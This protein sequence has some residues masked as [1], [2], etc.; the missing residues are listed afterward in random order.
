MKGL[1]LLFMS[2]G[3]VG[4][5]LF[6]KDDSPNEIRSI[7]SDV[8]KKGEGVTIEFRPIPVDRH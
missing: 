2:F 4:C 1:L 3:L 6:E 8:L 5:A 7:A